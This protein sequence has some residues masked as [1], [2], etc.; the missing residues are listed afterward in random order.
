M[1][2]V[3]VVVVVFVVVVVVVGGTGER[4]ALE[5]FALG[6]CLGAPF[7]FVPSDVGRNNNNID[8]E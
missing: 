2:L 1:W 3:D 5:F 4:F 7:D 6:G 8:T